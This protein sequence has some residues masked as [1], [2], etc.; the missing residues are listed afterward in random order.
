MKSKL[1]YIDN[2][3]YLLLSNN[4]LIKEMKKKIILFSLPVMDRKWAKI[5]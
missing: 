3:V 1:H 2:C 4:K 5:I